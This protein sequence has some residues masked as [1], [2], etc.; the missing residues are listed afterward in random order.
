MEQRHYRLKR[1]QWIS[2]CCCATVRDFPSVEEYKKF[3]RALVVQLNAGRRELAL[4]HEMQY[5]ES[6]AGGAAGKA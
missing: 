3:V 5:L 2:R 4:R 1:A 6:A